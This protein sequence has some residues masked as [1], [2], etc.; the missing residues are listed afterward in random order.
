MLQS[1]VDHPASQP[2]PS[3]TTVQEVNDD[4]VPVDPSSADMALPGLRGALLAVMDQIPQM[5]TADAAALWKALDVIARDVAAVKRDAGRRLIDIAPIEQYRYRGEER[6]RPVKQQ[7]IPGVGLVA[8]E[9]SPT[10]T[11]ANKAEL[12]Q[13]M[14]DEW[15]MAYA[16]EHEGETPTRAQIVAFIFM[17]FPAGDPRVTVMRELGLSRYDTEPWVAKTYDQ[18]ARVL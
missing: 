5:P 10:R 16:A 17:I 2:H 14:C 11:W 12:A 13:E 8:I 4:L 9:Q 6:T 7:I 1:H 18:T 3:R 15:A